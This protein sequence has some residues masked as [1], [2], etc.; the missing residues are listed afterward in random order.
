MRTTKRAF[1]SVVAAAALTLACERAS[2]DE[3]PYDLP[4]VSPLE[5]TVSLAETVADLA[6][7]VDALETENAALRSLPSV[8][9]AA[10]QKPSSHSINF[11]GRIHVDYWAFPNSSPGIN[12]FESGSSLISPQDRL[13]LRRARF[14]AFGSLPG[15]MIYKLDFELSE[16]SDPE[17]RDLY[18]GWDNNPLF[19]KLLLGNQKRPYGL[20]HLNS[21]NLNVMLERPL[22]VQ[23]FNRNNRRFGLA[24]H[25]LSEDEGW[26]WRYGLFNLREV[27][28]D[29]VYASDHYQL[30][31]AG[32]IAR[33]AYDRCDESRYIHL[34]MAGNYAEPD[35]TPAPGREENQARFRT[36]PEAR[37]DSTWLD[38]GVIDGA[39]SFGILAVENVVN[40]GPLQLTGEYMNLWLDREPGFGAPVHFHGGYLQLSYFLTDHYQPWN[41]EWGIIGRVRPLGGGAWSP[42]LQAAVRLS[43]ADL[44]DDDIL[45]GVGE[46]ITAAFNWYFTPRARLQFN[47]VYG[48]ITDHE[49]VDGFTA[50][51]FTTIGTR[52]MVDF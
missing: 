5:E 39:D 22:I 35:G 29:G 9:P 20:D 32:R 4:D 47:C 48:E 16:A 13:E 27:Q 26:N 44:S 11:A 15:D 52:V 8:T 12:A 31:F 23:A 43:F 18:I 14:A 6:A 3:L 33:S 1:W 50:G 45:G 38:T 2:A 51:T 37:T 49:P 17:F 24:T 40:L 10:Y 7:R 25:G 36:E 34:A 28:T 21:S 46:T 41:R 19:G 30:E 42:G